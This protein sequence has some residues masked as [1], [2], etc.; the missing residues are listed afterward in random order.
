[1]GAGQTLNSSILIKEYL[2]IVA[3][4]ATV[5]ELVKKGMEI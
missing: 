5:K 1:M 3:I 4:T 2:I